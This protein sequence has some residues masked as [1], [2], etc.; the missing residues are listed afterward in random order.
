MA[1]ITISATGTGAAQSGTIT[2]A[3][4]AGG[5]IILVANDSDAT[6]TFD[7]ATAGTTVQTGIQ[8]Q[9]KEFK[10]VTGLSNGAQTLVNLTTA[11]GTV[12][13][14]GDVVYNYLIT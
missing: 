6:I 4:G 1:T 8:L 12:A 9:A 10:K 5:G 3:G 13:Q 7:V 11:H 2:T 14:S